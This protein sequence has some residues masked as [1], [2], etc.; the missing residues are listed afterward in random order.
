MV[1]EIYSIKI[2]KSESKM[3]NMKIV[4]MITLNFFFKIMFKKEV[5]KIV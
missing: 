1:C 2:V 5:I 3:A 4:I